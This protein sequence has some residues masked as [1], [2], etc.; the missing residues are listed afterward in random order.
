M[1][2]P[3]APQDIILMRRERVASLRARGLSQR[4]IQKALSKPVHE[5]GMVNQH[6]GN[7][8]D[9]AQIN[10]DLKV[11]EAEW[12]KRTA[13]TLD[14]H[15]ARQLAELFELKRFAWAQKSGM[16]IAKALEL[17]IKLMGTG[18]ERLEHTGRDGGP[19]EHR[20]VSEMTNDELAAIITGKP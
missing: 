12:R 4:E 6:T 3:T 10:R 18:V 1:T 17:D 16:L 9:L 15:K 7:P 8:F 19:I 5:G 13:E 2:R 20:D 11:L 14:D